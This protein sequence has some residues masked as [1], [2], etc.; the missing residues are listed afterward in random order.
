[1][2]A[3]I[4]TIPASATV[5]ALFYWLISGLVGQALLAASALAAVAL[6]IVAWREFKRSPDAR[7]RLAGGLAAIGFLVAAII[8][9]YASLS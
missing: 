7:G 9:A 8:I 6:A 5:A 3:W 1:M 2:V 4:I